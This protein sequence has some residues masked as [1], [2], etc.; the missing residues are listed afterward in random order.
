MTDVPPP[1]LRD[2]AGR[3]RR[4]V[5]ALIVG[6]AAGTIAFTIA[7]Q[8]SEPETLTAYGSSGRAW[9]LVGYVTGFA[10]AG[11]FLITLAIANYVAKRRAERDRVPRAEV[12]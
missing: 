5:L 3:L 7:H 1:D 9:K 2:Q 6:A 10:G 4:L 12:R 11:A 8:M